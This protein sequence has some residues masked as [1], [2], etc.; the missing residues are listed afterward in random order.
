MV[1]PLECNHILD[2]KVT[3]HGVIDHGRGVIRRLHLRGAGEPVEQV[4]DRQPH[5]HEQDAEHGGAA[6]V[7]GAEPG[8]VHVEGEHTGGV[9]RASGGHDED[10]VEVGQ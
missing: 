5:H 3:D 1:V 6:H 9:A 7:V 8:E 2:D 4:R 10:E